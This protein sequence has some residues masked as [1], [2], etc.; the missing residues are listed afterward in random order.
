MVR[1]WDNLHGTSHRNLHNLQTGI[2][3]A[4][5]CQHLNAHAGT[6]MVVKRDHTDNITQTTS[7]RQHHTDNIT[8]TTSHRQHHTDNITQTTS[9]RQHRTRQHRTRQH[10]TRQH[11]TRQHRTRQHHTDNITQ[12]TSHKTPGDNRRL[13]FFLNAAHQ[14]H[15][16]KKGK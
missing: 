1:S 13:T 8:Q 4:A 15:E 10:R 6:S 16:G 14:I 7:H 11:R 9:H 12:T 3:S 2:R 5:D